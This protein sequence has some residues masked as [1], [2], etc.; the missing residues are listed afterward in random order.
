MTFQDDNMLCNDDTTK[1]YLCIERTK[2]SQH[3]MS[4]HN[5]GSS[6]YDAVIVSRKSLVYYRR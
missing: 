1:W 5:F 4:K 6:T 2:T 3:D